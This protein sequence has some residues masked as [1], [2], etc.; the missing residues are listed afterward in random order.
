[1]GDF[2]AG[3]S[4]TTRDSHR[5]KGLEI[6]AMPSFAIGQSKNLVVVKQPSF[7]KNL[8]E[9]ISNIWNHQREP[10]NMDSRLKHLYGFFSI[11]ILANPLAT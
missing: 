10:F 1:M 11:R 5:A 3:A 4:F 9:D 6:L 7:Q 8:G 2:Q